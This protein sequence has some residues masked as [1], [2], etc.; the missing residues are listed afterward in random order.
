[1]KTS[2]LAAR[3]Q[4]LISEIQLARIR[5]ARA[6]GAAEA[7]EKQAALAKRRRKEARQAA[8]RAK[9]QAKAARAEFAEA[10]KVLAKLEQKLTKA[11]ERAAKST[12]R[13]SQ[14]PGSKRMERKP[15]SRSK[16][17][18]PPKQSLPPT[19]VTAA[20]PPIVQDLQPSSG[21]PVAV[22]PINPSQPTETL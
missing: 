2:K 15:S 8:R 4:K 17:G 13:A 3:S 7:A 12:K 19:T 11:G 14:G 10:Q 21:V 1:M 9:K 20:N 6:G 18:N 22:E 16:T 5:V